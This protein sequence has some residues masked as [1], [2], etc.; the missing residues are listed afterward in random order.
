MNAYLLV[1]TAHI[2]SATILFGTG[3]GTAF[4]FYFAH[5][6]D[7]PGAR[8]FA[9]RTTVI[10]DFLF[11]LPAVIVQPATGIWLILQGPWR[12]NE[13]WLCATYLL[14][15]T[16]GACWVPVVLLQLRMKRLL[17]RRAAGEAIDEHGYARLR[18]A[19]FLL[20][21]PAFGG[22]IVVFWL[23]VAKPSW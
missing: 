16:A 3:L 20:G 19:W 17:E 4:F 6:R 13:S 21:W 15:L 18:R 9:A 10:A 22:L 5:R 12:W 8:L 11:T 7:D 23:M 1:K 14:Y 2:V